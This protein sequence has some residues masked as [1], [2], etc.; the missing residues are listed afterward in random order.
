MK[1]HR[2]S[3]ASTRRVTSNVP[4]QANVCVTIQPL[5]SGVPSEK[6]QLAVICPLPKA[7]LP[8]NVTV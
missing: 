8:V 7:R 6:S 1:V 4:W 3:L 2:S 5:S